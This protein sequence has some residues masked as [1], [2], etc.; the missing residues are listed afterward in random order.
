[1][2]KK[3]AAHM[4]MKAMMPTAMPM[5]TPVEILLGPAGWGS[6]VGEAPPSLGMGSPGATWNFAFLAAS[7]CFSRVCVLLGLMAPTMCSD[8]QDL[9]AAQ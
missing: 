3:S 7:I 9:G 2:K 4:P 1:M 5:M 8:V 6:G